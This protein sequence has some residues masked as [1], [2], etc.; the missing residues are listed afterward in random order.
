[1]LGESTRIRGPIDN[2]IEKVVPGILGNRD[3]PQK[4]L[5]PRKG[6]KSFLVPGALREITSLESVG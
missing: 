6:A 5:V 1:M 2:T 4:K 3:N